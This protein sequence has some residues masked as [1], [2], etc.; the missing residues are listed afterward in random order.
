M[1]IGG[2]S[3]VFRTNTAVLKIIP[4]ERIARGP[5]V[6][7]PIP[8][9][10]NGPQINANITRMQELREHA[11]Y[12]AMRIKDKNVI[13]YDSMIIQQIYDYSALVIK[14]PQYSL[15]LSDYLK[16]NIIQKDR[17]LM[18]REII[19]GLTAIHNAGIAHLDMKPAN[20]LLQTKLNGHWDRKTLVITDFGLSIDT[21]ITLTCRTA[22]TPDWA[23]PEQLCGEASHRSDLYSLGKLLLKLLSPDQQTAKYLKDSLVTTSDRIFKFRSNEEY[24]LLWGLVHGLIQVFIDLAKF[25]IIIYNNLE[26]TNVENVAQ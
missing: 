7:V 22:G 17:V 26:R 2:E 14:M 25:V 23:S 12:H 19:N 4:K 1:N 18:A 13:Q 8:M 3:V 6:I 15:T 20:I 9:P 24:G 16:K 11:E 21:K 10:P 5:D